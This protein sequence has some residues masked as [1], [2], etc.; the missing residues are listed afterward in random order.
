MNNRPLLFALVI[1]SL[2]QA[3]LFDLSML[4]DWEWQRVSLLLWVALALDIVFVLDFLLHVYFSVLR[5]EGRE[6]L[7][8][9]RGWIDFLA[10]VVPLS[11]ASG[12]I[13]MTMVSGD[14]FTTPTT[15]LGYVV[16][17]VALLRYL[18]VVKL[19]YAVGYPKSPMAHRHVA[20]AVS[21]S[22]TIVVLVAAAVSVAGMLLGQDVGIS[23]MR[24]ATARGF[25][26]L[27]VGATALIMYLVLMPSIT[28]RFAK[29]VVDPI[30]LMEQGLS[31]K[32]YNLEVRVPEH[33]A[34]DEVFR[35]A[36]LYNETVLPV[37]D[38]IDSVGKTGISDFGPGERS[39]GA[40]VADLEES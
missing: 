17:A 4:L 36:T 29:T 40:D 13:A 34:D 3:A 14:P 37:K 27:I 6:Y 7:F 33:Y 38:T 24:S 1:L 2:A 32:G 28:A 18:R 39:S 21:S 25:S 5:S 9:R 20:A 30:H 19:F 11:L 12:P 31:R 10:S 26:G 15:L 35:L 8:R 23:G 16:S 22:V